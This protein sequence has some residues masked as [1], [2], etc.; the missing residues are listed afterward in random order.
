MSEPR[1]A[2]QAS[3]AGTADYDVVGIG[4]ALV[5]VLSSET[6]AF[7]HQQDLAKGSMTYDEASRKARLLAVIKRAV[8]MLNRK[9]D[10]HDLWN[11]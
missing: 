5:D 1:T 4:N 11:D 10:L 9:G 3:P 2:E 6:D 7:I 8:R